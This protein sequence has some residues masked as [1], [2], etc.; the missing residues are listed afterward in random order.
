MEFWRRRGLVQEIT[1][2]VQKITCVVQE[3]TTGV[4]EI[5]QMVQEIFTDFPEIVSKELLILTPDSRPKSI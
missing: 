4:Q 3:I 5:T 2:G 1:G